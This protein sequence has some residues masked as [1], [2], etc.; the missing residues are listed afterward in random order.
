MLSLCVR[1][2]AIS[3]AKLKLKHEFFP[4]FVDGHLKKTA[5][6]AV[7]AGEERYKKPGIGMKSAV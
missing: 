2:E 3:S 7:L 1:A 5:K 4:C 6:E